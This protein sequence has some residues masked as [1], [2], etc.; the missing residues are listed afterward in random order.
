MYLH[1]K[2]PNWV[3]RQA[4]KLGASRWHWK[5][6]F[7]QKVYP[8]CRRKTEDKNWKLKKHWRH[9]K[10]EFTVQWH[11]ILDNLLMKIFGRRIFKYCKK[12]YWIEKRNLKNMQ[13]FCKILSNW[14]SFSWKNFARKR[15]FKVFLGIMDELETQVSSIL[16]HFYHCASGRNFTRHKLWMVGSGSCSLVESL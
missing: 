16:N 13:K 6:W 10:G 7:Q 14:E 3:L 15:S 9:R 11:W 4:S 1:D 8:I 12:S 2:K 5:H